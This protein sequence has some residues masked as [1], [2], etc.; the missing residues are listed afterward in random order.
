M[1]LVKWTPRPMKVYD[2]LDTMIK[3][4]FNNDWEFTPHYNNNCAPPVDIKEN[5]KSFAINVDIPGFT[6][7]DI[8]VNISDNLL[9]ISG[10]R[11]EESN[12]REGTFH[13]RERSSGSFKRSFNLPESINNDKITANYRNGILNIELDKHENILPK[14]KEIKI[15]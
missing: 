10:E 11:K 6:K 1:T 2:E 8:K 7:K 12:N 13:Y 9:T 5:D 4:I 15:N 3:T 14:E